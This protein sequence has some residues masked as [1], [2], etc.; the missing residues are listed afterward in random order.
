[1]GDA[2]VGVYGFGGGVQLLGRYLGGDE[3]RLV[4]QDPGVEDRA[5]LA[6]HPPPLER[7]YTPDDL[8]PRQIQDA[9]HRLERLPI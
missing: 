9:P 7:V 8:V 4:T 1:V 5:D 6:Y 2:G 3:R